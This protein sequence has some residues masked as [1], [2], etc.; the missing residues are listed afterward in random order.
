MLTPLTELKQGQRAVIKQIVDAERLNALIEMGCVEGEEV[1]I[2]NIAPYGDP[3]L[4]SLPPKL[5]LRKVDAQCILVTT[6]DKMYAAVNPE[7]YA[8]PPKTIN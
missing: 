3:L 8:I 2:E 6:Y 1:F 4:F 5:A 7:R